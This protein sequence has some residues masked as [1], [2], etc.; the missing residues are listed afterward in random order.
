[1]RT[2]TLHMSY[3]R[4][5]PTNQ[6]SFMN[7]LFFLLLATSLFLSA[8]S[9]KPVSKTKNVTYNAQHNLQLDVYAP[10]KNQR[11]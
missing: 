6:S 3:M 1:M 5:Y 4:Y 2:G 10:A 9:I 7:Y 11:A 8:C